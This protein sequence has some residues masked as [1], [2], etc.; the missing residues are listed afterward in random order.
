M[1]SFRT[2]VQARDFTSIPFD[3]AHFRDTQESIQTGPDVSVPVIDFSL[4]SSTN[5]DERAKVI[6]D[7]GKACEEWGFF[8]VVNH[9]IPENLISALFN[10]CNEFF[11]M[12]E[13][14]K[15][16]FDNKNPLYSVTVRS[17][18]TGGND[19]EQFGGNDPNQQ[20]KLWRDYL[21]FFV[22]PEYHCPTKP[23][24]MSDIVLE[25]SRR[26]R[27]LAR[28]LLRGISQSLGLEEDYIEKAMELDSGTQLF[29]ANYYPPCPQ[30]DLAIG[31][32]PHTDPGLLTFLLQNGVEGLEIQNKGKWVRL[33]GIPGAIFVNT[34]DQLEII[35]N[36]KYK[37]VCHRAVLNNKKTRI[38][39]VVGN[40]PSPDTIA[41]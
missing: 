40:G 38:S 12:P 15:L 28:K 25:Y 19:N 4:L 23:K 1:A 41:A 11:D 33:T 27:D 31:I 7:L 18:T 21:R 17:G 16:Q 26:T 2:L 9:G 35:S 14:D 5:P 6:L 8:L 10:V 30:P 37:S 22:H 13:E 32:P 3:L 39:L 29:A 34:A 20:V 36:G 24:E